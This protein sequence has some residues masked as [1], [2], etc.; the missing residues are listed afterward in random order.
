ME[1]QRGVADQIKIGVETRLTTELSNG[2]P[3]KGCKMDRRGKVGPL[4]LHAL[5]LQTCC[6]DRC[7]RSAHV[8]AKEEVSSAGFFDPRCRA[9]VWLHTLAETDQNVAALLADEAL[10]RDGPFFYMFFCAFSPFEK[11]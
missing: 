2:V 1:L 4:G 10:C 5:W 11:M 9:R 3:H 7:L 6:E 8:L